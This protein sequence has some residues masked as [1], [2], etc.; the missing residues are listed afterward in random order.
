MGVFDLIAGLVGASPRPN[1]D[2]ERLWS[3]S[4]VSADF[5]RSGSYVSA[6]SIQQLDAVAAC[7]LALAGP[8]S[9]LPIGVFE[10]ADNDGDEADEPGETPPDLAPDLSTPG[11]TPIPMPAEEDETQSYKTLV[12]DHP[13]ARL[14]NRRPNNRQTAQEFRDEMLRHLAIWRNAYAEMS[15]DPETGQV[16]ALELIH[17]SRVSR[18]E[19]NRQTGAIQYTINRINQIGS[20]VL[21]NA[22]IWHVRMAPLTIDGLQGQPI[23][24]SS[25]EVFGRALAVKDYGAD[26]FRNSGQSGGILEHPGSF[27]SKEDQD[28][29]MEGWRRNSMGA[30]RHADRMLQYGV[31]YNAVVVQNDQAQFIESDREAGLAIC[32]LW[33]IPPHRVGIL[34]RATFS[35]IEQQSLDF[36]IYTIAPFI[37]AIEQAI[38]RDL[39]ADPTD[40]ETLSVEVNVSGLLRGDIKT[41]YGAYAAGRQWGW[42][43]VNDIRRLENMKPISGGDRY[44]EPTNM[45][46]VGGSAGE[47]IPPQKDGPEE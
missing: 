28:K 15:F 17:P 6:E 13:V 32:R 12:P 30:Q 8:L 34:D 26:W 1:P 4:G 3:T 37:C 19:R 10:T 41:R 21:T 31:K 9:T 14:F 44:L 35:N 43:S 25:R 16:G 47:T 45:Q 46:Q 27:K 5:A 7:L 29:F 2:D 33:N 38:Q 24:T 22:V 18:V 36:V 39:L 40:Q 23:Y 11:L 42:L 20:D